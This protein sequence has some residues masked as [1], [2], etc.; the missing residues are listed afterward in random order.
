[1]ATIEDIPVL[2]D[3]WDELRQ[4]G[5]RSERAN[6]PVSAIDVRERLT[7]VLSSPSYRILLATFADV[8]AGMA[9]LQTTRPDP[10]ADAKVLNVAHLVVSRSAQHKGVGHALLKAAVD[11][12]TEKRLD[13][14]SVSIY[15]SLREAN[16]FF[17][18]LGFAPAAT[19]RVAP[20]SLLRRRLGADAGTAVGVEATRRRARLVRSVPYP[21]GSRGSA[22]T[23]AARRAE[24]R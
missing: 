13:Q 8:P 4:I 17:A 6:N 16:R 19:R 10:F 18:R 14:V 22:D 11:F 9:V 20:V 12:A 7:A 23:T 3:L 1:M 2:V 21:R 24:A 5:G 15:P